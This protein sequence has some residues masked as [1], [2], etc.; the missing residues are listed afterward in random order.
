MKEAGDVSAQA[1]DASRQDLL[2]NFLFSVFLGVF[3]MT[4]L[5]V[6]LAMEI[7]HVN[8]GEEYIDPTTNY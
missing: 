5:L 3:G 7:Y 8:R 1:L 4:I 2:G 6:G